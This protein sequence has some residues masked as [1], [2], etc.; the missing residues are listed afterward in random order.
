M[1]NEHTHSFPIRPSESQM[2]RST[3]CLSSGSCV[4]ITIVC[5]NRRLNLQPQVKPTA[6]MWL[7]IRG[8]F[9]VV[10]GGVLK[11]LFDG[12]ESVV[13]VSDG[14][15]CNFCRDALLVR[16]GGRTGKPVPGKLFFRGNEISNA[17][18]PLWLKEFYRVEQDIWDYAFKIPIVVDVL[19]FIGTGEE[20]S[21]TGTTRIEVHRVCSEYFLHELRYPAVD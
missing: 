1:L 9:L 17:L 15:S 13:V 6:G 11:H 4:T 8:I 7:T 20:R 16:E 5:P 3:Y 21:C 19:G 10:F 12:R 2:T 18:F 14:G